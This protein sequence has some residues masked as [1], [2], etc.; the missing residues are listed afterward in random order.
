MPVTK[1]PTAEVASLCENLR[2]LS[3]ENRMKVILLLRTG[4][5]CVCDIVDSLGLPQSLVS[6]HLAVLRSAGF[7]RDR[8]SGK[9]VYYAI[10]RPKMAQFNTLFFE[11]LN[12][13]EISMGTAPDCAPDRRC[14]CADES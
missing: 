5:R 7:L 9:W 1:L 2:L 14:G 10:D 13:E 11:A 8:R 4:E 3:D 6:H 12:P